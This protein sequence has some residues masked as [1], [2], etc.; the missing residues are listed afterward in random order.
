MGANPSLSADQVEQIL[1]DSADKIAGDIHPY[2]G[3]GRINVANAVSMAMSSA[4]VAVDSQAPSANIFS[5]GSGST[6][7]G[8]VQVDVN[9]TD[10]V[11]VTEV[12][13]Y[14][15]GQL[16]GTDGTAPYQFSWD[17][18]SVADGSVTLNA[19]SLDAAGNQGTSGNVSV[20]VKNQATIDLAAP[21]VTIS[22]P[23]D[24]SKVTGTVSVGV[25]AQDDV[26]V[27]KVQLYL[28]GKLVSSVAGATLSYNWNTRKA[29]T[30][31]HTIAAVATDGSGKATTRSI[32]VYK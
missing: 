16:V 17:S 26:S 29:S 20:T 22:K 18:K 27:A 12:S 21:T 19:T 2:Y 25:S 15:N 13:L 5:P 30:G 23:T 11:G 8:L 3:Y 32:T 6:V 10:N 14:A 24:G 31:A 1:K 7:S 28:D 4:K 9:A